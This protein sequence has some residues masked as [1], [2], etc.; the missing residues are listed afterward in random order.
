[1]SPVEIMAAMVM[2]DPTYDV[3][4]RRFAGMGAALNAGV[5]GW[6]G[7]LPKSYTD[8]SCLPSSTLAAAL[9]RPPTTTTPR[10]PRWTPSGCPPPASFAW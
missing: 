5:S 2:E 6:L 9:A 1:M 8:G 10:P 3:V 4:A 7:R